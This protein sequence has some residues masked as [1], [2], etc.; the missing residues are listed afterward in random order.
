MLRR[1]FLPIVA[2]LALTPTARAFDLDAHRQLTTRAVALEAAAHPEIGGRVL[3]LVAANLGE[4]LNLVVKWGAFNHY[5]NPMAPVRTTWRATSD[6]RVAGL[7]EQLRQALAAGD[8]DEVWALAG[9]IL[10]HVQ[11]MASPPHVVPVEHG[12]GDGF[13]S[14]PLDGLVLSAQGTPVPAMSGTRAHVELAGRTWS[15]VQTGGYAACGATHTWSEFW[16]AEPGVF[17]RYG[18]RGN[19]FGD[20]ACPEE[21]TRMAEFAGARVEDAVGYSRAWLRWVSAR[22]ATTR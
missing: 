16:H 11:D 21:D 4:D 2:V 17:G 3:D 5:F 1:L 20:G 7:Q 22:L 6:T 9:A 8:E 13:E 10:H 15:V 19:R 12:V 14:Y 18:G